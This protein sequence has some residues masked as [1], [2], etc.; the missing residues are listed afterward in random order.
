MRRIGLIWGL[1]ICMNMPAQ[2][3]SVDRIENDGRRQIMTSS[4]NYSFDGAKYSICMKVYESSYRIDWCLLIS[5]YF[6]IPSSAEILLKLGNDELIYL[7]CNNVH[8]GQVT[9]PGYGIPIG[10]I[11]YIS[12]SIEVD[13]YSSIYDLK[14]SDLDK[15]EEYGIKKIRISSGTA[16]R[17]KEFSNNTL[18]KFLKKCR[19]KIQERLDNPLR[20]K[21]LFDDF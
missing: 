19:K 21:G 16:Y 2:K 13:Y 9:T 17:D 18:G 20:K 14:P 12:P 11:T 3:I 5:S 7:P 6:Y 10:S 1:A 8:I 15:I 4:K